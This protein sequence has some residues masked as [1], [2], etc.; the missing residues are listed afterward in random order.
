MV[1]IIKTET[2]NTNNAWG[3]GGWSGT[4]TYYSNGVVHDKGRYSHR[5]TPSST[6]NKYRIVIDDEYYRVV[7]FNNPHISHAWLATSKTGITAYINAD[8]VEK[9][10]ILVEKVGHVYDNF[11]WVELPDISFTND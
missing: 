4:S 6:R 8:S 3:F 2:V 11:E 7:N 1:S 10:K 9:A 5:H